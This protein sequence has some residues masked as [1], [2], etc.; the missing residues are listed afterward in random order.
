MVLLLGNAFESSLVLGKIELKNVL[1][2]FDVLLIKYK[3]KYKT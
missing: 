1:L 2:V 3:R